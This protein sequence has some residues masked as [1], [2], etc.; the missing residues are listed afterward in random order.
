[1]WAIFFVTMLVVASHVVNV[2]ILCVFYRPSHYL[3][4]DPVEFRDWKAPLEWL[5]SI[6]LAVFA[7]F[8]FGPR[9]VPVYL[10]SSYTFALAYQSARILPDPADACLEAEAGSNSLI[11]L[12]PDPSELLD[13]SSSH[14]DGDLATIRPPP[15]SINIKSSSSQG[16]LSPI[17]RLSRA[18]R[19][20]SSP[21]TI[22]RARKPPTVVDKRSPNPVGPER[23]VVYATGPLSINS[24][25]SRLLP[26]NNRSRTSPYHS[27]RSRIPERHWEP[28]NNQLANAK[29]RKSSS[30][31][32]DPGNSDCHFPLHSNNGRTASCTTTSI[33]SLSRPGFP[34]HDQWPLEDHTAMRRINKEVLIQEML[35]WN[36]GK[37]EE[38]L[39]RFVQFDEDDDVII[40]PRADRI[41]MQWR[42]SKA[43]VI[44][45]DGRKAAREKI[46]I[47]GT[48][49]LL[50][51]DR[52]R[53]WLEFEKHLEVRG[54][55]FPPNYVQ[56][57]Q[58][59]VITDGK[60]SHNHQ[61]TKAG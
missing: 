24:K 6:P 11:S 61:S 55:P 8:Y 35:G 26:A 1:M 60:S 34:Q 59:V 3:T 29:R 39:K 12:L 36:L 15:L 42:R 5:F 17:R 27:I 31:M 7:T 14:G 58:D 57:Y 4:T 21:E 40:Q 49:Q 48:P 56:R 22:I 38:Q 9:S 13:R 54:N 16:S 51:L 37:T 10:A 46:H 50:D 18:I 41:E 32:P 20:D 43:Q 30:L 19:R 47:F 28:R 23:N 45:R 52:L 25:G 2:I 44:N 33:R 53:C